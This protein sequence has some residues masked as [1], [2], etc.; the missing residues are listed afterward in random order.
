MTHEIG[1]EVWSFETKL[2]Y[3]DR[4]I[5]LQLKFVRG[6]NISYRFKSSN[7]KAS[8]IHTYLLKRDV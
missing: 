6:L 7:D 4:I 5:L 8:Q 3:N 1:T 2:Y